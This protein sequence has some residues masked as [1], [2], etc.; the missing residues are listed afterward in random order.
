M[1]VD[2]GVEREHEPAMRGILGYHDFAGAVDEPIAERLDVFEEL[3]G[4]RGGERVEIEGELGGVKGV[5]FE[6]DSGGFRRFLDLE[7]VRKRR[8]KSYGE[9]AG[10]EV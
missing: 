1:L 4:A 9:D 6:T 8:K 10:H 7:R 2:G 5:G 3:D